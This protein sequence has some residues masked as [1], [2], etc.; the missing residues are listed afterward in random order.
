MTGFKALIFDMDGTVADTEELH[1]RAFNLAFREFDLDWDWTPTL[2]AE[3]LAISG[4]RERMSNYARTLGGPE[5]FDS[6]LKDLHKL[7]SAHYLRM[8]LEGEASLRLGVHRLMKECRQQGL[9][10]A[11]ATSSSYANVEALLSQNLEPDWP[12]WFDAIGTC[13][14]VA[15]KKPSPAVYEYVLHKMHLTGADCVALED[16]VSGNTAANASGLVTV[17]TTHYFTRHKRFPGAS[18]VINH[19][20]EPNMPFTPA[21]G[22]CWDAEYVNLDLISKLHAASGMAT[23]LELEITEA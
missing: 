8:L 4:G 6:I 11:I 3:L 18:L 17:I 19:L 9:R 2:Y 16:T 13:D 22:D 7:K 20:G 5:G 14:V 1:R 21:A 10:M 15:E 12:S 23:E